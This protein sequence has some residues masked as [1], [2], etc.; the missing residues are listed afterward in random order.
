MD[1]PMRHAGLA[2]KMSRLCDVVC[3][4]VQRHR[5]LDCKRRQTSDIGDDSVRR[6]AAL[7]SAEM[8]MPASEM[9]HRIFRK[10][11]ESWRD[12]IIKMSRHD[13]ELS[14]SYGPAMI[15]SFRFL[16]DQ[17]VKIREI[18]VNPSHPLKWSQKGP[19]DN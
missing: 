11:T 7:P 15:L 9:G 5:Y 17:F 2:A 12:R 4:A 6:R 8:S 18:R 3:G 19:S 14:F 1:H 10:G 13:F 16:L